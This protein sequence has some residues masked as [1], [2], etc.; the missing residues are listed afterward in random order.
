MSQFLQIRQCVSFIPFG[1]VTTYGAIAAFFGLSDARVIGWALRNNPDPLIPCHRV[2]KK[3]GFLA[4]GFS[5]GNWP[6]QRRR[7]QSEGIKFSGNQ[8]IDFS[9]VFIDP[10]VLILSTTFNLSQISG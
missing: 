7:L 2:V 5:L 9:S 1:R 6:E 8:I 10:S 4:S 3:K